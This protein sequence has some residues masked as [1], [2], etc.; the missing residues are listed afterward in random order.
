MSEQ[1]DAIFSIQSN[2]YHVAQNIF[3][4]QEVSVLRQNLDY[5]NAKHNNSLRSLADRDMIHNCHELSIKFLKAYEKPLIV[6]LLSNLLGKSY[7]I[8]AFQSSSLPG[9]GTN[10]AHRI[11]CD[12]PRVIPGY[13][14]NV[15]VIITLDMYTS[16]SGAIQFMPKSFEHKNS[17]SLSEFEKKSK[18]IS[19]NSGSVIFF[20]ARTF[21]REGINLSKSYRHSLT[22][23]FCR[24]YMRQRFD[25]VRMAET[26]GSILNMTDDQKKL[27]GYNVRVPTSLDE[28]FL[29]PDKRMYIS[30]QE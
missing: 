28:F 19:C 1:Q 12:S 27:I 16:D 4:K 15:G 14:S 5:F 2:G 24:C 17:P 18:M 26:S 30:G 13:I 10:N 20:N 6:N 29:P 8:Y 22:C 7:I 25:F 11:H 3:S 21:H 9:G 23:N